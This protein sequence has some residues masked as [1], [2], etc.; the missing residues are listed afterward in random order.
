MPSSP[1]TQSFPAASP[2]GAGPPP[3]PPPG[4][5]K[6]LKPWAWVLAI[7][8]LLAGAVVGFLL[9]TGALGSSAEGEVSACVIDADGSIS[10]AGWVSGAED[11]TLVVRFEDADTGVEVDRAEVS[12]LRSTEE[13]APWTAKG[14]AG[15]EVD[16]VKCVLAD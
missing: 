5:K 12:P 3:S 1:P 9:V 8:L 7:L 4:G 6:T 11:S 13:R 15:A 14:Q 16:R 10:A 2:Q